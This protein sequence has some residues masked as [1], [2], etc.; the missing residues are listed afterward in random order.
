MKK[1]FSVEWP[2]SAGEE[3]MNKEKLFK[4][5]YTSEHM[6][7]SPRIKEIIISDPRLDCGIID[8]ACK[9]CKKIGTVLDC[10]MINY[11]KNR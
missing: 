5:I 11:I 10:K 3:W 8:L 4:L 1:I 7:N 2:D 6:E 9:D